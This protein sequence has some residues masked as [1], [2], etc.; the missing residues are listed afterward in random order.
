M[1]IAAQIQYDGTLYHGWQI[2]KNA[3]SIQENIERALS[4]IT[5]KEISIVGCGRTDKGVHAY[6]YFFH[7]D[8]DWEQGFLGRL[9]NMLPNSI[10]LMN[11]YDAGSDFHARFDAESRTYIYRITRVKNPFQHGFTYHWRMPVEVKSMNQSAQLL[12]GE[13]DFKCFSK[14]GSQVNNYVCSIKYATWKEE[15]DQLVFK[16]TANRFLRNMVRAIVGTLLDV[17]EGKK[18]PQDIKEILDS[19]DRRKAGR[20]VPAS[21]L[22]LYKIDYPNQENW[23]VIESAKSI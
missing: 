1:R 10:S 22:G 5:Q 13:K 9:N 23:N 4:T 6:D 20:S 18:S 21:G 17:G 3:A 7:A 12:L 19:R 14:E 15:G 11:V 16:I 2:Q 8:M